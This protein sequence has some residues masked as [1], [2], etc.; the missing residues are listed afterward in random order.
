[1]TV[2]ALG[3]YN[4][5]QMSSW[6]IYQNVLKKAVQETEADIVIAI[7]STSMTLNQLDECIVIPPLPIK[8]KFRAYP[9]LERFA[10]LVAVSFPY[11]KRTAIVGLSMEMAVVTFHL[12]Q[13]GTSPIHII[14]SKCISAA[15]GSADVICPGDRSLSSEHASSTLAGF[16]QDNSKR[17]VFMADNDETIE[18]KVTYIKKLKLRSRFAWLLY[19]VHLTDI[20][21]RC[22]LQTHS[23]IANLKT[24][25]E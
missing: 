6:N 19:N 15:L 25:L 16:V 9:S 8:I 14:Y 10:P 7:S 1:M 5:T 22:L 20:E 18:Q 23:R 2:I 3:M 21:G 4:Y 11:T 17:I 12:K 13:D 24:L